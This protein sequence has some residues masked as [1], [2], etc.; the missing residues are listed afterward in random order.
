MQSVVA[1]AQVPVPLQ[2]QMLRI[3]WP[4][5]HEVGAHMVPAG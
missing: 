3:V 5:G 2:V 4:L 1:A